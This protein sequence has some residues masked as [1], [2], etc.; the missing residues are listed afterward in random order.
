MIMDS[1]TNIKDQVFGRGEMFTFSILITTLCYVIYAACTNISQ[2]SV[3]ETKFPSNPQLYNAN[4]SQ[5]NWLSLGCCSLPLC[6]FHWFRAHAAGLYCRCHK[7]DQS[8]SMVN[9][10]RL[11]IHHTNT[12]PWHD[13]WAIG[14]GPLHMA[15][16]LGHVGYRTAYLWSSTTGFRILPPTQSNEKRAWEKAPCCSARI[17]RLSAMV[18]T[19]IRTIMGSARSPGCSSSS[20]RFGSNF[21]TYFLNG[22]ESK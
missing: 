15:L 21:D 10:A 4:H 8:W 18:E 16:G 20:S 14:V 11:N 5:I 17:E 9:V 2:Y 1:S 12:I 6:W 3:C 7:P 19:G 22:G 13:N